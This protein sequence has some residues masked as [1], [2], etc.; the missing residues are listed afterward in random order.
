MKIGDFHHL[1]RQPFVTSPAG[2]ESA[3]L[4]VLFHVNV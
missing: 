3:A 1:Q 2:D 4:H